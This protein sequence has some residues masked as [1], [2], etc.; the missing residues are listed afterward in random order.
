MVYCV[1]SREATSRVRRSVERGMR[2]RS[3]IAVLRERR[4]DER[5][6]Q[7]ERREA[8]E[9]RASWAD[10]RRIRYMSGRRVA[11][12]RETLVPVAEPGG[13]PRAVRGHS[14]AVSFVEALEVP[15]DFREDIETVRAIVRFQAGE[16]D[17]AEL[18]GR[19]FDTVYT[20][21]RVTLDRATDVEPQV[22]AVF[23]EALRQLPRVAPGPAQ[24]RSWLFGIV[25]DAARAVPPGDIVRASNGHA[26]A[27]SS[28]DDAQDALDWL[29]DDELVLLIERRP[30]PERHV[31]V[32][33]YFAGLGWADIGEVMAVDPDVALSLHEMA[34]DSLDSTLAAATRSPRVENR[35]QMG[36]LI[37]QTPVLH[38]RRRAL[39]A[40]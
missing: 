39:L 3:D 13:L 18:Y 1:V 11:E 10:R 15:A 29:S 19:W 25:Y 14:A 4:T 28:E 17:F 6:Q 34:V 26:P 31:L 40:V 9:P 37:Q 22:A 12:R 35:H 7:P 20:Y 36:R 2:D 38:R 27:R 8:S 32:L 24:L 23:A 16:R 21:L 30:L 5:R 33:R